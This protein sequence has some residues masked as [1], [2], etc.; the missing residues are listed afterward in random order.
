MELPVP[1]SLDEDSLIFLLSNHF[2]INRARI[3]CLTLMILGL[4]ES[5]SICLGKLTRFFTS[6]ALPN[7]RYRRMQRFVEQIRFS[8]QKLAILLLHI[9]GLVVETLNNRILKSLN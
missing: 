1:Q 7:S 5:Q 8:P 4:L 2:G 9:I 3:K 6:S